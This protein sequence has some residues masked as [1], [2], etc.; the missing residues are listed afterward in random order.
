MDFHHQS[1]FTVYGL[2]VL[3]KGVFTCSFKGAD[4]TVPLMLHVGCWGVLTESSSTT[5]Y[6]KG[7]DRVL[8][9]GDSTGWIV[10][11]G[12]YTF[13]LG[14]DCL[15]ND[16]RG[17]D[18]QCPDYGG[19]L[20]D[21]FLCRLPQRPSSVIVLSGTPDLQSIWAPL[22]RQ[23]WAMKTLLARCPSVTWLCQRNLVLVQDRTNDVDYFLSGQRL[24]S[25]T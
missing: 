12:F 24:A 20:L 4:N 5:G 23:Q 8:E 18:L 22:T 17:P 21:A 14:M 25:T 9:G 16:Q 7:V 1:S 19:E 3:R 2:T 10:Q 13:I 15:R 11:L 6:Y